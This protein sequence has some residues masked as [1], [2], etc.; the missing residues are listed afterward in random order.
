MCR[1]ELVLVC[2]CIKPH[3]TPTK[4]TNYNDQYTRQP[5]NI[6]QQPKMVV[7]LAA[8]LF[9]FGE[10]LTIRRMHKSTQGERK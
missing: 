6:A 4:A 1:A 5:T 9:I 8:I 10:S 3:Q 7:D 2:G